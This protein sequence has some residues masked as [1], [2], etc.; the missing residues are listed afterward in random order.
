MIKIGKL[1]LRL[2]QGAPKGQELPYGIDVPVYD[3][4]PFAA[5]IDLEK[6]DVIR[7]AP[8]WMT[9]AERLLLFALIFGIRPKHYLEI[10]TFKGGS[11]LIAAA[12]MEASNNPGRLI[13]IDPEPQISIEHWE[14][15]KQRTRVLQG[16]SPDILPRASEVIGGLFDFVFIDGDHSYEGVMRDATGVLPF[17]EKGAYLLFH[18]SFFPDVAEAICDFVLQHSSH[19]IDFGNLTR[20]VTVQR[21]NHSN[22]VYWGGLRMLQ[23]R[24]KP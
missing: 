23:I 9:R 14:R 4:T 21:D 8:C 12:A 18:D 19:I 6:L 13:C 5:E 16:F 3:V 1:I 17:V 7:W 24:I 11:A 22:P 10:G 20:E 2:V 15:L